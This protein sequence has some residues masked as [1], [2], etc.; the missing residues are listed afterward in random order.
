MP[1]VFWCNQQ[2]L[3]TEAV[4][5]AVAFG[6]DIGS[7][8]H[9]A[10]MP[11]F[12]CREGAPAL[13]PDLVCYNVPVYGAKVKHAVMGLLTAPVR[14]LSAALDLPLP[15]FGLDEFVVGKTKKLLR[16]VDAAKAQKLAGENAAATARLE[17]FCNAFGALT[18][19]SIRGPA[20]WDAFVRSHVTSA[21][22]GDWI[23]KPELRSVLQLFG[24]DA[25]AA[26]ALRAVAVEGVDKETGQKVAT[27]VEHTSLRWLPK[28]LTAYGPIGCFGDIVNLAYAALGV[29]STAPFTEEGTVATLKEFGA[30]LVD[31]AK[32]SEI[33]VPTHLVMDGES[34]DIMT[35]AVLEFMHKSAGTQLS[36]LFQLPNDPAF[37]G[38]ARRFSGCS[39]WTGKCRVYRDPESANGKAISNHFK[40]GLSMADAPSPMSPSSSSSPPP[41]PKR[42]RRADDVHRGTSRR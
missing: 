35:L 21:A 1:R 38:L 39:K 20:E 19:D 6:A 37:D 18:G 32:Y 30:I 23:D 17:G 27:D 24:F 25:A 8:D 34:D 11:P 33:W 7:T 42:R 3:M 29:D 4:R 2:S 15:E 10:A 13:P 22:Q 12:N 36:V 16:L 28:A 31:P 14:E 9:K 40:L 5:E 26:A 41:P